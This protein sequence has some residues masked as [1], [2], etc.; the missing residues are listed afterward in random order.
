MKVV[1]EEHKRLDRAK[2]PVEVIYHRRSRLLELVYAEHEPH[3]LSSEYLRIFSP[4]A[5]IRGHTPA[6]AVL[7]FG[8]K[9]VGIAGIEHQGSYAIKI[10]F[11]DKHDTGVYS[12]N[13]LWDLAK[14][15]SEYWS[16]Y[17]SDLDKAGKSRD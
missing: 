9:H 6:Q 14:K 3:K 7:Q 16:K 2:V 15:H 10:V 17:L 11:D 8:K 1:I 12:W 4:S 5:D 13:Y